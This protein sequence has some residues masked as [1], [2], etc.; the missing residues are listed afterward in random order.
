MKARFNMVILLLICALFFSGIA[1]A[2][3][4]QKAADSDSSYKYVKPVV[5]TKLPRATPESMGINS[6]Y[7]L[8]MLDEYAKQ[9]LEVHSIMI[10]VG[11]NVIFEGYY[12]PYNADTPYI[13][14]SLTKL[15]TNAAVGMAYTSG[16]LKLDD[17]VVDFFPD[18]VPIDANENLREMTIKS[19]IT[20]RS[21]HAREIRG[22][23]WR[24]LETS[25]IDAFMKEPVPYKPG[26]HYQYSSGNSYMLSAMVQK[27]TGKTC[28]DLL[29]DTLIKKL[30]IAQFSWLKS[31]EGIN[32]GGNGVMATPE[33]M[34][35]VAQ[36]Y[37]QKGMWNGERVLSE[38]WCDLAMGIKE[39]YTDSRYAYHW[40]DRR[41]GIY[42]A[43]GAFGQMLYIVPAL[44]MTIVMTAGI[45]EDKGLSPTVTDKLI[46][47]T[48]KDANRNYDGKYYEALLNKAKRLNVLPHTY[49]T[50]SPLAEKINGKTFKMDKNVDGIT[51]IKLDFTKDSVTYTMKDQ[52]GTHVVKCGV[53]SYSKGDT[54][55][56]GNYLH[57][58]YQNPSAIV[59]GTAVWEDDN[60]LKLT[61][62]YPEM[63]FMDFLTIKLTETDISMVRSVNTNSPGPFGGTVRPEVTG[64]IQSRFFR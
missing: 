7:I 41:G 14:H 4:A 46:N 37:L 63:A 49:P 45:P 20:M 36:L 53:G 13:I 30:G 12:S 2:A 23:E 28:E 40:K 19:L 48:L 24:A 38:E 1:S 31:P 57:H 42:S 44:D 60:T 32:S 26:E 8:E 21:G 33:D 35:K 61:W 16:Q 17:K 64:K 62:A 10:A 39:P 50:A 58:Q 6:L 43:S 47:R 56:T 34:L 55:M 9:N 27:A 3:P 52:R 29:K 5:S 25:W 11:G 18:R 15:F 51:E 59:H 54:T 22:N